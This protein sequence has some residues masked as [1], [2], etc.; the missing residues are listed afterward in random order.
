MRRAASLGAFGLAV[1]T[2]V[3]A[4]AEAAPTRSQVLSLVCQGAFGEAARVIDALPPDTRDPLITISRAWL[5]AVAGDQAKA[6]ELLAPLRGMAPPARLVDACSGA[7][8]TRPWP[9]L[10]EAI[11][12]TPASVPTLDDPESSGRPIGAPAP[13]PQAVP[14]APQAVSPAPQAVQPAPPPSSPQPSPPIK[15]APTAAK[16]GGPPPARES[17]AVPAPANS[18][19]PKVISPVPSPATSG[20]ASTGRFV[21]LGVIRMKSSAPVILA[22]ARAVLP[23]L[24]GPDRLILEP[25]RGKDLMRML[26]PVDDPVATCRALA[27]RRIPCIASPPRGK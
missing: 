5:L 7:V 19:I 23:D 9:E 15:P 24:P 18:G 8:V 1:A 20:D 27:D 2:L 21:Q 14:P 6:R 10:L 26:L 4:A 3:P 12:K 11:V 16:T 22:A 13:A 17:A 25:V